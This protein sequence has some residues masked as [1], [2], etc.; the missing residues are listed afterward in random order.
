MSE[1]RSKSALSNLGEVG[2]A[3]AFYNEESPSRYRN[4][5]FDMDP[6]AGSKPPTSKINEEDNPSD[7]SSPEDDQNG[8]GASENNKWSQIFTRCLYQLKPIFD[9]TAEFLEECMSEMSNS[10]NRYSH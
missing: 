9:D 4:Q 6:M 1:N 5:Y 8:D 7:L 3:P 2:R 10:L